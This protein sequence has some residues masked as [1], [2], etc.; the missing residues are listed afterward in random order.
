[1]AIAIAPNRT[2]KMRPWER[3]PWDERASANAGLS[4]EEAIRQSKPTHNVHDNMAYVFVLPDIASNQIANHVMTAAESKM[5][6]NHWESVDEFDKW[7][8]NK[9]IDRV[10]ENTSP[11]ILG[12]VAG[13]LYDAAAHGLG[14][15]GNI[16]GKV[17]SLLP[18]P[19]RRA[20]VPAGLSASLLATIATACDSGPKAAYADVAL[21]KSEVSYN[22][23]RNLVNFIVIADY[24]SNNK[25][26]VE[27]IVSVYLD[28]KLLV[29]Q[30]GILNP[31]RGTDFIVQASLPPGNYNFRIQV[32]APGIEED[33]YGNNIKEVKFNA[34]P[35]AEKPTATPTATKEP[36]PTITPTPTLE[37][38]LFKFVCNDCTPEQYETF[39]KIAQDDYKHVLGVYGIRE[40]DTVFKAFLI[41]NGPQKGNYGFEFSYNNLTGAHS[42]ARMEDWTKDPEDRGLK[43]EMSHAVNHSLFPTYHSWFDEGM[44]MYASGELNHPGYLTNYT[45]LKSNGEKWFNGRNTKNVNAG[46]LIG[47]SFFKVLEIDYSMTPEQNR[48]ALSLLKEEYTKTGN[49][50]A[51]ANIKK[52]YETALGKSLDPLFDLLKPGVMLLYSD[53]R[54]VYTDGRPHPQQQEIFRM[55]RNEFKAA[56]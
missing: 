46:H 22:S 1:M 34:T 33:N 20:L 38:K 37:A 48:A 52:A 54:A 11:N 25:R 45:E 14:Y 2:R 10:V 21:T 40:E 50:L 35:T 24:T 13:K 39:S 51:K 53:E 17:I 43:H 30:R 44:A 36:T 56:N 8:A 26:P 6:Q 4:L 12:R 18:T 29:S 32:D 55:I 23:E 28:G 19:A 7:Y 15:F 49:E 9:G 31:E 16:A 42:W 27:G 41:A 3:S 5:W 47:S